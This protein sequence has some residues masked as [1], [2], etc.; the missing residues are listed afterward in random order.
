MKIS[1]VTV[2]YIGIAS[3]LFI[4][5]LLVGVVFFLQSAINEQNVAI[6]RQIEFRQLGIDIV[7]ASDYLTDEARR[8][9]Q[10]GEQVHYDNYWREVNETQTRDNVVE[11][12]RELGAPQQEL[13]LIAQAKQ[14]SDTLIATEAAA[15]E[16]V[17]SGD[18]E[19]ARTL[20]FDS[21]YDE[22]KRI[23]M[24]PVAQF[25]TLMNTRAEAEAE[26]ASERTQMMLVLLAGISLIV[27]TVMGTILWIFYVQVSVPIQNYAKELEAESGNM[28][29]I[30]LEPR[31]TTEL[32]M[33]ASAFN[34]IINDL[35]QMMQSQVAKD[36]I[37]SVISKYQRFVEQVT[38]GDLTGQLDLSNLNEDQSSDDLYQL[39]INLNKMVLGLNE[40]STQVRNASNLISQSAM[41]IQ[42]T[43]TQQVS[44]T[45]EQYSAITQITTTL[46]EVRTTSSQS[47]ES[48]KKIAKTSEDSMY[49]SVEGKNAVAN[50][51]QGMQRIRDQVEGIAE[52]ILILSERT[53]QI[54]EIIDVVSS[55]AEQSKL[56][57]LNASI[58]A[59]RA[60]EEGR[61]FA[62]VAMEVRQ[63]AEQ[64]REAT[65]RVRNILTEIQ[66][67]TN[68]AV[69]VTEEGTKSTEEG[70]QLV[71][72]AG[73]SIEKLTSTIELSTT[74][75]SQIAAN[76][77]QQALGIEQLM[78]AM[79]QVQTAS[80]Q[81]MTGVQQVEENTRKLFNLSQ[82]LTV[83]TERY[84]L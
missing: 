38:N 53:Q 74:S 34:K 67:A 14:H 25:Q 57:A 70:V 80:D 65:K 33:L 18:F 40:I 23:I 66:Q 69:I 8:Y 15:F 72:Q 26:A 47:S 59:A 20:M 13:D 17:A 84:V 58:E 43:S 19:L 50:T 56:L 1:Q 68:S 54:G 49:I 55:L 51:I 35:Q 83:A 78:I 61:G 16:A 36:Y 79:S 24:E 30:R 4:S 41:D 28:A 3:F 12:L 44:S 21:N 64:S 32:R 11:R 60:G 63:L 75:I 6:S 73:E 22:A 2:I 76:V 62:V 27:P 37:E 82:D 46:Q 42:A 39:G 48:A 29:S 45:S 7:D 5:V 52:N 81:T 10:F 71:K 9:V 77:N 31:G